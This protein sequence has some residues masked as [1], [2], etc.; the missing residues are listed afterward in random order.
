MENRI[1]SSKLIAPDTWLILGDGCTSYLVAGSQ[2]GIMID[3]GFAEGNIREYASS[4]T[5]KPVKEV[6]NTHEHFDHT[7]LDG[8]F[9]LAHMT[10]EAS[11]TARIPY[12]DMKSRKFILEYPIEF[13]DDG[14][15]LELGERSLEVYRIPS[16]APGSIAVLDRKQRLLFTGDEVLPIAML[17]YH[18]DTPQPSVAQ[19]ARNMKRLLSLNKYYDRLC[20]GHSLDTLPTDYINRLLDAAEY[21][22]DGHNDIPKFQPPTQEKD[23]HKVD[24]PFT[25]HVRMLEMDGVKIGYD[26]RYIYDSPYD[27][28]NGNIS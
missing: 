10:R 20:T 8:Q 9:D 19:F 28:N 6:L 27:L 26:E 1:Y 25:E 3:T 13:V 12:E 24:F 22:L 21:I 14:S 23:G 17:H 2:K 16:H 4:L 15:V 18:Q 7:A 5:D 11:E